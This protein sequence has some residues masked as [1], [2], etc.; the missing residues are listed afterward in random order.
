M[1]AKNMFLFKG[2]ICV[3]K[4]QIYSILLHAVSVTNWAITVYERFR[5]ISLYVTDDAIAKHYVT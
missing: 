1:S 4:H 5:Q 2:Q 3:Y